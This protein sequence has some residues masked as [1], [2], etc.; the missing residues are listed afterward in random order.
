MA[1]KRSKQ[2]ISRDS[3]FTQESIIPEI[4]SL[5]E[6][7]FPICRS[8]TGE[9]VRETLAILQSV[10]NFG[11]KAVPSGTQ[12]FDWTVPEEWEI[13]D[14]YIE[15]MNGHRIIS[16]KENNVH[17]VNYS[18]AIDRVIPFNQLKSHLHSLPDLPTAIPY[19]T[20]YYKKDWGFCLTHEQLERM[21]KDA[22]YRVVISASHQPGS[23][24]Y[25][26]FL[27][28]GPSSKE[29]LIST[30]CCHPSLAN[31]NLSGMILWIL[32]L[33][34]LKSINTEHSYRFVI[35]PETIGAITYL[36][37]NVETMKNIDGGY[38]LSTVAGPGEFGYSHSFSENH[39]IDKAAKMAMTE[40][41]ISFINY[42]FD[43]SGSDER[44]FSSP[45]FRI[46]MGT[47][48][49]DKYFEYDYYHTSLD[50]LDFIKPEYL[51]QTLKLYQRT[52]LN[53]ENNKIYRSLN[54]SC[55]T[56]LGKRGLYPSMGGNQKQKVAKIKKKFFASTDL[57]LDEGVS[58]T[59]QIEAMLWLMFYS[60]GQTQL[61]DIAE[62]TKISVGLLSSKA[63]LLIEKGL[64]EQVSSN[65]VNRKS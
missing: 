2:E 10:S 41:D 5:F 57:G 40:C 60:D 13:S 62:K 19:R 42:P 31:D 23:L 55:E 46:P 36:S 3:F 4:E 56:M 52:I 7:L 58:Q 47:I 38:V 12:V 51:L 59:A 8:L 35:A 15:D 44:Q 33:R 64:L 32:L 21:D 17:V 29:Y 53:L 61:I 54:Q 45:A 37:E 63:K 26:E 24:N 20:S 25:G 18:T 50:N 49:K 9:G 1:S 43:I 27:M 65:G 22:K 6:T 30:Y 48:S 39:T 28:N 11:V 16:F 14:A 34:W